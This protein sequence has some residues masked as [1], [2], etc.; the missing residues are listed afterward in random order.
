MSDGHPDSDVPD[1]PGNAIYK[2]SFSLFQVMDLFNRQI[3]PGNDFYGD[4]RLR[5]KDP[6]QM[7]AHIFPKSSSRDFQEIVSN[8]KEREGG[9]RQAST[10]DRS[11]NSWLGS[12]TDPVFR[13]PGAHVSHP[14]IP[15]TLSQFISILSTHSCLIYISMW[16]YNFSYIWDIFNVVY[17]YL[18][19]HMGMIHRHN[20]IYRYDIIYT[21]TCIHL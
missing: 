3:V 20:Y 16:M 4:T 9:K 12:R 7:H 10:T 18:H 2:C 19:I 1:L 11:M 17:R 13:H 5:Q 21:H 14:D 6:G 15:P 8:E